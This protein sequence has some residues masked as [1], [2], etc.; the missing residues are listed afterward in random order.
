MGP[1]GSATELPENG[2]VVLCGG[3]LGNA[4][5]FSIGKKARELGNRVVYFA[6]YKKPDDFYKREEIEAASDVLILSVDRGR[7]IPARRPR[8]REFVGNIV[9][10]MLAYGSGKM[11]EPPV[12]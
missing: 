9:E 10:S 6:G 11:G 8:D 12:P 7:P 1:T 5:L 3:G 4:V 2:T